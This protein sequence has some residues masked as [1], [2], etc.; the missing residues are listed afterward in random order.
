MEKRSEHTKYRASLTIKHR[1]SAACH[2]KTAVV[3]E[4]VDHCR[5]VRHGVSGTAH[6]KGSKAT[7]SFKT[8]L[9]TSMLVGTRHP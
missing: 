3:I 2:C 9:T 8:A 1:N 7:L 4:I 6:I 5:P